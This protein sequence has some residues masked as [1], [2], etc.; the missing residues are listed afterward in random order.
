MAYLVQKFGGTS[1]ATA[2]HFRRAASRVL[3][4]RQAGHQVVVVVSAMATETDRLL[5]MGQVFTSAPDGRELDVVLATG[6]MLSASLMAL[7]LQA[8]GAAARSFLGF[9]LPIRTDSRAGS[10]AILSVDCVPLRASL[11]RSEIPVIA[12]FQGIDELGRV[13]TLGRGGSDTTAVAVAAALGGAHCEIYTDVDG[14]YSADPRICGDAK[15]LPQVSYPFMIEAAGLGAKVMHDRSVKI[16]MQYQVPI[17]VKNSSGES[18]GT[19]IGKRE[20]AANCVALDRNVARLSFIDEDSQR[21]L[22]RILEELAIPYTMLGRASCHETTAVVPHSSI[23]AISTH[24]NRRLGF[25]DGT[26]ARVSLVGP[27]AGNAGLCIPLL[28]S[29]LLSKRIFCHGSSMGDRSVSFLVEA[30]Q[31][32]QTARHLH[33]YSTATFKEAC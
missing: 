3:L 8:Q 4:A 22:S 6:E 30:A 9:Q 2:E 27:V 31:A 25:V 11:V 26:L 14:V 16:A 15:L 10:A 12:G 18:V 23:A 24:V 33:S 21:P 7:A 1:L 13:T 29:Q 20:T 28:V 5:Q 32:E 19:S 17:L